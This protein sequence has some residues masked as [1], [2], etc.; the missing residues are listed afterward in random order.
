MAFAYFF[1]IFHLTVD[2]LNS[3]YIARKHLVRLSQSQSN[4]IH[5]SDP[6]K[7]D[8]HIFG[9]DLGPPPLTI[10]CGCGGV[11]GF[12]L[13]KH[14]FLFVCFFNLADGCLLGFFLVK[15]G[16]LLNKS[17]MQGGD[18]QSE[19]LKSDAELAQLLLWRA[20]L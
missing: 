2:R 16:S 19:Q 20:D 18:Q 12:F 10:S 9:K 3:P 8:G 11:G 6:Q 14:I 5:E 4:V 1:F 13:K 17:G 15:Q 7:A